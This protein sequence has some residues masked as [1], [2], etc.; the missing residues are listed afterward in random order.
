VHLIATTN[1]AT[2]MKILRKQIS[3][4]K[5][6]VEMHEFAWNGDENTPKF[7]LDRRE[8]SKRLRK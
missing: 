5:M 2:V 6:L 7:D 8:A 3:P 4:A 1:L